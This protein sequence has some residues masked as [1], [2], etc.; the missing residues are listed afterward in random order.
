MGIDA[1]G[2]E[3]MGLPD[4]ERHRP[5]RAEIARVAITPDERH[6]DRGCPQPREQRMK[7]IVCDPRLSGRDIDQREDEQAGERGRQQNAFP[8]ALAARGDRGLA[9]APLVRITDHI[10]ADDS[11]HPHKLCNERC[12]GGWT[13]APPCPP[14]P[15]SAGGS[16]AAPPPPPPPSRGWQG[17]TG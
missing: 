14:P 10:P 5:K 16:P 8:R 11:G 6:G 13:T 3:L 9:R 7:G 1:G 15:A 4:R 2:D 17:G 12:H